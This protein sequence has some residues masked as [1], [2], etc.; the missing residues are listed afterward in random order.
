M[1][2]GMNT[3][4]LLGTAAVVLACAVGPVDA[5]AAPTVYVQSD[6]ATE[7]G[8]FASTQVSRTATTATS[9]SPLDGANFATATADA[10]A[11]SVGIDLATTLS[12]GAPVSA[13]A[14]AQI[15]DAW[16]PCPFTCLTTINDAPVTFNMHFDGTLSPAWLAANQV[17]GDHF[18]FNG[19]FHVRG[20]TLDFAWNGNQLAG[21]FCNSSPAPTCAPF[22]FPFTTLADGSLSFNDNLSF[23]GTL[24]PAGFTTELTL[25]GD[26]DSTHRPSDLAFLHSF[27]FDIVSSDPNLAWCERRGT[28][29]SGVRRSEPCTGARDGVA[30]RHGAARP[31]IARAQK[32]APPVVGSGR[33]PDRSP[34]TPACRGDAYTARPRRSSR[35]MLCALRSREGAP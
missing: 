2:Q 14:V 20:D 17:S 22:T 13:S 29:Y 15:T 25:S 9:T 16:I 18:E 21:T 7:N 12:D 6:Y 33:R 23:T 5:L 32:A 8:L 10:G 31:R 30:D 19:S 27:G 11:D 26:W 4:L 3:S 28:G 24:F 34:P 1:N 35:N